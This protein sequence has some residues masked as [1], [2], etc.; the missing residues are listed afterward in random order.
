MDE[1][2]WKRAR[3]GIER[4][5]RFAKQDSLLNP[6]AQAALESIPVAGPFISRVYELYGEESGAGDANT[7]LLEILGHLEEVGQVAAGDIRAL[8]KDLDAS[9]ASLEV[10]RSRLSAISA[11]VIETRHDLASITETL[12]K[13]EDEL[14]SMAWGGSDFDASLA[15]DRVRLFNLLHE[16]LK[17]SDEIFSAQLDLAGE[18]E[19][20]L[21]PDVGKRRF[22]SRDDN[23]WLASRTG[24]IP[25]I[26]R[27]RWRYQELRQITDRMHEVNLRVRGLV[28]AN[29][30][31]LAD[32]LTQDRI[33]K[34]DA[35][36]TTWLAKYEYMRDKFDEDMALIFVGP[37]PTLQPFP[38]MNRDFDAK[39]EAALQGALGDAKLDHIAEAAKELRAAPSTRD[40]SR[41]S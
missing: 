3:A 19:R 18:I 31:V 37:A 16:L 20:D 21:Y 5:L 15:A 6:V 4:V 40:E 38:G 24:L 12:D 23:L 2:S 34:L 27:E 10:L 14:T 1:W 39:V 26:G 28:R 32:V 11:G 7:K 25:R 22:R 41:E 9:A 13:I 8:V 29:E 17:R 35:H 33:D 36:L 30:R